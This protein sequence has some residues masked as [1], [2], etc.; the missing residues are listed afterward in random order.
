MVID[1]HGVCVARCCYGGVATEADAVNGGTSTGGV[2][3]RKAAGEE[4]S[5]SLKASLDGL[6]RFDDK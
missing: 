2:L 6:D 3:R 1:V 5:D 4:M